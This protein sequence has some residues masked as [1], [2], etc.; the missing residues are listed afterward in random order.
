MCQ[1]AG[2]LPA[3]DIKGA[4][5]LRGAA[6]TIFCVFVL[7]EVEIILILLCLFDLIK[8]LDVNWVQSLSAR[9][10]VT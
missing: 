3:E 2:R 4:W 6:E 10:V 5:P 7:F 8:T 1:R 9:F